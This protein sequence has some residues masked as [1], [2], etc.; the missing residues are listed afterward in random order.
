M[1][2][3]EIEAKGKKK[4]IPLA[5]LDNVT[6]YMAINLGYDLSIC[7]PYKYGTAFI[8]ALE[9]AEKADLKGYGNDKTLIFKPGAID[10]T[11]SIISQK[12]YRNAKMNMLLGVDDE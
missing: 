3:V 9:H 1:E 12:V 11:T 4:T 5:E 7:L 6:N 8:A 10:I 2:S